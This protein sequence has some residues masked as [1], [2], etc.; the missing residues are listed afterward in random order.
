MWRGGVLLRDTLTE[1]FREDGYAAHTATDIAEAAAILAGT[2]G[3]CQIVADL[4]SA[5][6]NDSDFLQMRRHNDILIQIPIAFISSTAVDPGEE[7][8]LRYRG[9]DAYL[10]KPFDVGLLLRIA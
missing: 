7:C 2:Q 3:T 10:K 9:A 1:I 5:G 4:L 8:E 6:M